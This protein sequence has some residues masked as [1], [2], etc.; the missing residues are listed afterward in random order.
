VRVELE[1]R[2][3]GLDR[4]VEILRAEAHHARHA[5][6][7]D[8]DA[9]MNRIDV[10]FERAAHAERHDRPPVLRAH[11]HDGGDFR[12]CCR[13]HH[14]VRKSRRVPRLTMA[15]VLADGIGHRHPIAQDGT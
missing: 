8:R 4:N 1:A 10:S 14:A 6:E 5:R 3:S 9:A 7:I 13:K 11:L 15:V 12:R 2:Q